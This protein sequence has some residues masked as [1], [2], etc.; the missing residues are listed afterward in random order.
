MTKIITLFEV[1]ETMN[2]D[3]AFE[4]HTILRTSFE[5]A[6]KD[7]DAKVERDLRDL[8]ESCEIRGSK[9]VYLDSPEYDNIVE[10]DDYVIEKEETSYM[11]YEYGNFATTFV[12]I[13]ITEHTIEVEV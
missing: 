8:A 4:Q 6:K 10:D 5:E 11:S 1:I 3:G 2:I 9:M 13:S 7:F 12:N